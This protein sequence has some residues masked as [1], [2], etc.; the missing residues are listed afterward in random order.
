M[1]RK[2]IEFFGVRSIGLC[3]TENK[4]IRTFQENRELGVSMRLRGRLIT[5][6]IIII[7]LPVTLI[8]L[9]SGVIIY[10]QMNSIQQAYDVES[11]TRQIISNP[12][13]ILNRLT[14]GI[15]NEIKLCAL[16]NPERL[17]D[18]DYIWNLDCQLHEKYSFLAVRKADEIMYC[19]DARALSSIEDV[20][21]EFGVYN[22]DVDGG[23]YLGGR[24]PYLVK[25]QDF[26]YQDGSEGTIFI[27]T[28]LD[29]IVPQIKTTG[30]QFVISFV[31]IIC[32]TALALTYWIYHSMIKPLNM[33]RYATNRIK[34]GDLGY[35]VVAEY[36]DEIGELCEDF[37]EM[38]I[39]L[40]ELID[41][42]LQA[43]EDTKELMS[44]I[45]HDLKTPLTAIKG[46]AEG[47]LDGVAVTKEK[48]EKYIRTIYMKAQDMQALVDELS[49]YSKID[50]NTVP[51][52]FHRIN[53]AE[54]FNDCIEELRFDLEV[55]HIQLK[56][57]NNI[58]PEVEVVA[59]A[60]QVKRVINNIVGNSVKYLDKD[61]GKI[62]ICL[63]DFGDSIQVEIS[64]NGKGI[65]ENDLP[66]IFDRFYRADASRNSKK[67]G[68]GLGLAIVKKIIEEHGGHVWAKS[69][70][71]QGTT[72]GFTLNKES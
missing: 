4:S 63:E 38:R 39:R 5:S 46:Y 9:S 12:T 54:Y 11:D 49:F 2:V 43:E 33:L 20:L 27:L 67:G 25:Q 50:C 52:S 72:I 8:L 31:V 42:K 58:S 6:F 13:Q 36:D 62:S 53:V 16:K 10:Y 66:Y 28:N 69:E 35:E 7:A 59:D 32:L 60:E 61:Q 3:Y 15:Y 65:D 34:E 23:I 40:K 47:L 55:K 48:Q 64:D 44:N 57:E 41:N 22:T 18:M 14:R 26:Y 51:Y 37:E 24:H 21:P 29:I 1:F 19:E 56:F 70:V 17:E 71:E 68:S 45:S 30:V